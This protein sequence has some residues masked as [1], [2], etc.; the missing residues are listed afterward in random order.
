M[1][2]ARPSCRLA[3]PAELMTTITLSSPYS[4]RPIRFLERVG[5]YDWT[6]KVYSITADRPVSAPLVSAAQR[7]AFDQLDKWR[8]SERP[9]E[10]YG[11]AFLIVHHGRDANYVL[12]D[13]WSAEC[14]LQHHV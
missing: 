12:L 11:A 3:T 9:W 6:I 7:I 10:D 4:T 14:I 2:S 8:A 1:L 5:H 13:W